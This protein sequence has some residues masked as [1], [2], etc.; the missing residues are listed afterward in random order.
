MTTVMIICP[1]IRDHRELK[2]LGLAEHN[3]LSHDYAT[4]ELELLSAADQ[5]SEIV[6]DDPEAEVERILQRCSREKVE[7]VASTDDYPGTTLASIVA[8]RLNLP[9][10]GTT[11][12]LLCQ[13]KYYSRLVQRAAAPEA[14][15]VFH[16]IDV[17]PGAALPRDLE[18]PAFVKPAKSFFSVGAQR[19]DSPDHLR[20]IQ[21]HWRGMARFFRPF[22]TLLRRYTGY[23]MG[24]SFLIL[25][26]LL[27][28]HQVTLDGYV[29]RGK[30]HPMGVVDSIMFPGTIAFQRFEYPSALPSDV[31]QR[32]FQVAARVMRQIEFDC[33]QFNIE[34]IY[35]P[36]SDLISII[37][38]NPRM[39]SQFADLFEKVDGT[40]SYSV[41]LDLALGREPHV[42]H[43]QGRYRMA[44][45]CVLR[46]FQ[47]QIVVELPTPAELDS[48]RER[49]PDARVE[50]LATKGLKLSQQMQDTCSYRYGLI[51]LGG[52][53]RQE[54]LETFDECTKALTFHLEPVQA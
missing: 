29:Y 20:S 12:N 7:A 10:V 22:E 34:F 21:Q 52:R 11:P 39:S 28:G 32:M 38:I 30:V 47:N 37:E 25:E 23:V 53:D 51:N 14:V 31:Q 35:D 42:T 24:T 36:D 6:I 4:A 50:I 26:T 15:P 40:N 46:T 1:T 18:F 5:P 27:K 9:G 3:L 16:L 44:A 17:S 2:R 43:G 13:H 8:E 45:S 48:I 41:M 33:G 19:V 54:I 49:H